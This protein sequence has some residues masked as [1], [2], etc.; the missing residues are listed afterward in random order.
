M[1]TFKYYLRALFKTDVGIIFGSLLLF[2]SLFVLFCSGPYFNTYNSWEPDP[3]II[4]NIL[5]FTTL[6]IPASIAVFTFVYK[7]MKETSYVNVSNSNVFTFFVYHLTLALSTFTASLIMLVNIEKVE[8]N[9]QYFFLIILF[10]STIITTVFYI[11]VLI[12]NLNLK[13]TL[14]LRLRSANKKNQMLSRVYYTE[15]LMQYQIE[16][17]F[18][19]TGSNIEISLHVYENLISNGNYKESF[20]LKSELTEEVSDFFSEFINTADTTKQVMYFSNH[21][22]NINRLNNLYKSILHNYK[23]LAHTA[24]N[25]HL[26]LLQNE[27]ISEMIKLVPHTL[28]NKDFS[29]YSESAQIKL[30]KYYNEIVSTYFSSNFEL[31]MQLSHKENVEYSYLMKKYRIISE[32]LINVDFK[33]NVND[34]FNEIFK[35]NLDDFLLALMVWAMEK[36]NITLLTE[37][38]TMILSI[39]YDLTKDNRIAP[40]EK[41]S[42]PYLK[43]VKEKSSSSIDDFEIKIDYELEEIIAPLQDLLSGLPEMD[44]DFDYLNIK[45]DIEYQQP[46]EVFLNKEKQNIIKTFLIVM[47]KSIELGEYA[48]TGYILK[49]LT[50]RFDESDINESLK[51]IHF[52]SGLEKDFGYYHFSINEYSSVHC[53]KKMIL[54]LQFQLLYKNRKINDKSMLHNAID[55]LQEF[56]YFQAKIKAAG[57][58][59]GLLCINNEVESTLRKTY[60]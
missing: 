29:N 42:D 5:R 60:K 35:S 48:S 11:T 44:L 59:Y 32:L 49:I 37:T 53:Y 34:R 12:K 38:T 47:F 51:N 26:V 28:L 40:F 54:L 41:P 22:E 56:D 52:N 9:F 8:L 24:S 50:S 15:D 1:N 33:S 55:D 43:N 30:D 4:N 10:I 36:G 31:I 16:E 39:Y 27:F 20:N 18:E 7:E 57:K 14:K 21:D 19:D 3:A 45:Q 17:L 23:T 58:Q 46:E 6:L 13:R 2:F 25:H